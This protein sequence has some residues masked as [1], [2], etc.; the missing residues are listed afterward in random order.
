MAVTQ[1]V[2]ITRHPYADGSYK[3]MLIDGKWVEA[4]SSKRFETHNPATGDLLATVAEAG[5]PVLGD[6]VYGAG[7]SS[8][9]AASC[10]S[11]RAGLGRHALHAARLSFPSP[12][13]GGRIDC[14]APLPDDLAGA[15]RA[16]REPATAAATPKAR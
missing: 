7:A 2:P 6:S 11:A 3:K 10:A 9:G 8:G 13:D 14:A 1:A 16:L 4:A 5:Y 12:A 15:L